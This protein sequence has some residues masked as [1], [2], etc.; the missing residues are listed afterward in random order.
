MRQDV[1]F[2]SGGA[3]L[4]G[5]LYVPDSKSPWSLVVM[6]HG[7]SA[8][9]HMTVDKYAEIFRAAGLAV[10]LYDGIHAR[11]AGLRSEAPERTRVARS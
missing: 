10:L 8:T 5:W 11:R 3:E 9:R 6:T 4:N 2:S 7:F 1:T